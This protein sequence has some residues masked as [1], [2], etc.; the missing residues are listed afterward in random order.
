LA[1][2]GDWWHVEISSTIEPASAWRKLLGS[3]IRIDEIHREG[4]GLEELY[5]AATEEKKA[6]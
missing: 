2:T 1:R 4:G 5:L 6:A 3:G